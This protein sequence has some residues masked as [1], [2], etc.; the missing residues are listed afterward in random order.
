MRT[1]LYPI[2]CWLTQDT[3]QFYEESLDEII[4]HFRKPAQH[5]LETFCPA[6]RKGYD[7]ISVTFLVLEALQQLIL[8]QYLPELE[9][10]RTKAVSCVWPRWEKSGI[11]VRLQNGRIETLKPPHPADE[12]RQ[13]RSFDDGVQYEFSFYRNEEPRQRL[14]WVQHRLRDML[15]DEREREQLSRESPLEDASAAMAVPASFETQVENAE[16]LEKL[17]RLAPDEFEIAR[18]EG[19]GE[20]PAQRKSRQRA[21]QTVFAAGQILIR[22]SRDAVA[23]SYHDQLVQAMDPKERKKILT[24]Y[25]SRFCVELWRDLKRK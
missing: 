21:I 6:N 16:I 8:D 14:R 25:F 13:T 1:E 23:R 3:D 12:S 20:N 15:R 17:R 22:S 11:A 5:Y 4:R 18:G 2:V 9:T 7:T 10:G 19:E 24:L